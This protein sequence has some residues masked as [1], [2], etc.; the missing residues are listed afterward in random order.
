VYEYI[1]DFLNNP[2]ASVRSTIGAAIR[3]GAGTVQGRH[4]S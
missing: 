3:N 4:N 2:L 1:L